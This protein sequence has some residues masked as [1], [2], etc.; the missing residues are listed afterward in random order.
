MEGVIIGGF[1]D[2][3]VVH[4]LKAGG[5]GRLRQVQ[6]N[7]C[8]FTSA[9]V[10]LVEKAK[11]CV[12][13][14]GASV[15][16][17]K[18]PSLSEKRSPSDGYGH[19]HHANLCHMHPVRASEAAPHRIYHSRLKNDYQLLHRAHS[20][21]HLTKQMAKAPLPK[22]TI[23]VGDAAGV[24]I[25]RP[26]DAPASRVIYL[27]NAAF[28]GIAIALLVIAGRGDERI[29]RAV[30]CR[31]FVDRNVC[32]SP[33]STYHFYKTAQWTIALTGASIALMTMFPFKIDRIPV[34]LKIVVSM[35]SCLSALSSFIMGC[36]AVF[37]SFRVDCSI[38]GK[39]ADRR[40]I[41]V[42]YGAPQMFW[43]IVL[44]VSFGF[45]G[46]C[47]CL[48]ASARVRHGPVFVV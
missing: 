8:E 23:S 19:G 18:T 32:L 11:P 21:D 17:G 3:L 28:A 30:C 24:M 15:F 20:S 10:A 16:D 27:I 12:L 44:I 6:Q 29:Q 37:H 34:F 43:P 2:Q 25:D 41:D 13:A 14:A 42:L 35:L 46:G 5:D 40:A 48:C 39:T 7:L 9:H 33:Y 45:L 38:D 31:V 36:V 4:K 22:M 47:S 26:Q 1:S